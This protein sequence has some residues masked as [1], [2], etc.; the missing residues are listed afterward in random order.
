MKVTQRLL[1]LLLS[2]LM[3]FMLAGCGSGDN[4]SEN[5]EPAPVE[6]EVT[7]ESSTLHVYSGAGL[8]QAMD[9]IGAAFEE[10]YNCKVEYTYGGSAQIANQAI[11]TKT[12]DLFVPG[13]EEE[14]EPLR[15]EQLV[16]REQR[17]IYHVPIIAVP[18]DNP[19][20][21]AGLE[22]FAKPGVKLGLGDPSA[23]PIGK[24][25]NKIFEKKGILAD[26]DK[27]IEVRTP[28]VNE[29]ITYLELGQIQASIVWEE[30]TVN[31]TDKIKTIAI[32]ENEN[33]IKTIPIV[34][35]TC[36]E[37]KEMAAKF[38]EFC[39]TGEGKEIFK[40]LGYKPYDE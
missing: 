11:L 27:N 18:I 31:A 7:Y 40:E 8:R 35:L 30:N 22:D 9:P 32:P 14:V 1:V 26:V 17:V 39:A 37:N 2:L 24:I 33:Q 29:L 20:G 10:K 34:E 5:T 23:N 13:A 4:T 12:G 19:A 3:V 6:E 16:A 15:Q 36:A 38:I 25:A 28:T 21:I